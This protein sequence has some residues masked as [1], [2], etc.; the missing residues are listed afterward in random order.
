M[1]DYGHKLNVPLDSPPRT[2]GFNGLHNSYQSNRLLRNTS[3]YL[4]LQ[5][6]APILSKDATNG[7]TNR[8][9]VPLVSSEVKHD[10]DNQNQTIPNNEVNETGLEPNVTSD[11]GAQPDGTLSKMLD[12]TEGDLSSLKLQIEN[13]IHM[14]EARD[15]VHML[16]I[17]KTQ[18]EN[19]RKTADKVRKSALLF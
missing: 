10:I 11:S 8:R 4:G 15:M 18:V 2:N 7:Y 14:K 19:L 6:F 3:H 17:A 9:K 16:D 12:K 5:K 13:N 1:P